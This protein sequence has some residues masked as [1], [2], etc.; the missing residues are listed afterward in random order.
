[1][2]TPTPDQVRSYSALLAERFPDTGPGDDALGLVLEQ[3]APIVSSLTCRSIGP[4]GTPGDDVPAWLFPVA[5]RA[6]ALKAEAFP[7]TAK[8]RSRKV[9]NSNLRSISAGPWSESYFGPEEAAKARMLDPDPATHEALW[10]LATEECR[11]KWMALWTGEFA[12]GAAVMEIDWMR[13][14]GRY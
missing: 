12:P 10:A 14:S 3:V 9:A 5:R 4:D 8:A 11:E 13:G 6:V 7:A 2:V 1:M